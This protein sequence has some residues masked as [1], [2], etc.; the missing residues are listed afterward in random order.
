MKI[1]ELARLVEGVVEGDGDLSIKGLNGVDKAGEGDVTF[2]MDA[3]NLA[4]A[5]KGKASCV[6]ADKKLRKSSKT[7]IRVPNPKLSF[8]MVYN[9]FNSPR[10]YKAFVDPSAVIAPSARIGKNVWIGSNVFIGEKAGIGDNVI[11]ENNSVVKKNCRI[12]DFC[13]IH[14]NV[15]LYENTILK[16]KCYSAQR[17]GSGGGRLRVCKR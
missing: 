6:L 12:G 9:V 17:C 1:S 5:E 11:I 13:H 3:E 8:L 7:L 16:K 10:E 2:A 4:R 15:T 14:P